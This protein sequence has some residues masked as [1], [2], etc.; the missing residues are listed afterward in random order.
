M[1]REARKIFY[2]WAISQSQN[3]TWEWLQ[4]THENLPVQPNWENAIPFLF[5]TSVSE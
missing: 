4:A 3:S 2:N 1:Q 5:R